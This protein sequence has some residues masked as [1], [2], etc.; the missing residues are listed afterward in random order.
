MSPP[1]WRKQRGNRK[2]GETVNATLHPSSLPQFTSDDKLGVAQ[3]LAF[4]R[5]LCSLF[6][7]S[8]SA[9]FHFPVEAETCNSKLRIEGLESKKEPPHWGPSSISY[10]HW[11]G[12]VNGI[13]WQA[14][15][16]SA[17]LPQEPRLHLVSLSSSS[18]M[19]ITELPFIHCLLGP[20]VLY[21]RTIFS[22]C[23]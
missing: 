2:W 12:R 17:V 14:Q 18:F 13:T 21:I 5:Q 9:S 3:Y 22:S 6:F 7:V 1:V 20:V 10:Q 16:G 8:F 4:K 15:L 19:W 23:I 11:A